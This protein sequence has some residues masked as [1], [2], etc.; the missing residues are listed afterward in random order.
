MS[1]A[2]RNN[3]NF[4]LYHYFCKGRYS[5]NVGGKSVNLIMTGE[6]PPWKKNILNTLPMDK[7]TIQTE[8]LWQWL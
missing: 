4:V 1:T 5:L 8:Q 3:Q 6:W 2:V 7:L